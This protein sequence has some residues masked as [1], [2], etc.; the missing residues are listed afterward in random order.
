MS[1]PSSASEVKVATEI[2]KVLCVLDNGAMLIL[3]SESEVSI[4]LRF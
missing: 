4:T 1:T 2:W 3:L